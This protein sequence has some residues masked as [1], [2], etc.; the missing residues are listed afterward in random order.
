MCVKS[1]TVAVGV[2]D[3]LWEG[4]VQD[5]VHGVELDHAAVPVI[6]IKSI[7]KMVYALGVVA[8]RSQKQIIA[9]PQGDLHFYDLVLRQVRVLLRRYNLAVFIHDSAAHVT[10]NIGIIET[11]AAGGETCST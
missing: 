8:G 4:R 1:V 10:H 6:R 2:C 3:V 5:V 7:R 11:P 9:S